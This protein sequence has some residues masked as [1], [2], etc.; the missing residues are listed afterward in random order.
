MHAARLHRIPRRSCRSTMYSSSEPASPA[1]A[2]PSRL[3]RRVCPSGSSPRSTLS[4]RTRTQLRAGSTRRLPRTTPGN[5]TP[6]TRSRAPTTWRPGRRRDH[7]PR[8]AERGSPP[9]APWRDLPPRRDRPSRHAG[10][11]RRLQGS[12]LLRRRHHGPGDHA[13]ALRAA[14]E[15]LGGDL[16]LRGVVHDGPGDW[17]R[18]RVHRRDRPQHRRRVHGP[19]RGEGG[20]PRHRRQR[21]DLAAHDQRPDLHRRRHRDGLQR[22]AP[23]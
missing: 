2:Q 13:R 7:V 4:A 21:P 8:G 16:P 23:S 12:D 5:R 10:L 14:H 17:R 22:R 3:P 15:V 11:R 20:H 1:S 18:R 6:S 9:R 19:L